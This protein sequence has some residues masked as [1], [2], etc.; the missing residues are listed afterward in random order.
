MWPFGKNAQGRLED[1]LK[2]QELTAKLGLKVSVKDKVAAI[3]GQV[4]NER[5]KN[6]LKALATGINGIEDVDLSG[7]TVADGGQGAPAQTG[8]MASPIQGTAQ[9]GA[10]QAGAA[11]AGAAQAA[12]AVDPSALAKA[13][14]TGIKQE[15]SLQN[16]PLDVLQKGS[17]VVLRGAVDDQGEFDKARAI[18][19]AVP[20]VTGVD[21]SG[22]QVIANASAL[23]VTDKDGDIV[24]TVKSGDTLSHI[25]L[26]YYGSAGR[27]SYMKIAEANGIADP[28]KIRVG[29][30]LKIPGTTQGPDQVLA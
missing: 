16:N 1:A 12:D 10:A 5:Y 13:A 27:T 22:L 21:V 4:P 7:I 15:P 9:A 29:Q 18:A 23:N 6:L 25:A 14:L 19:L 11:Q 2:D 20:G 17:T 26:K 24:Y 30:V 28:N 3:S 8:T